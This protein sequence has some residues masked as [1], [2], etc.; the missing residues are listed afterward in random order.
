MSKENKVLRKGGNANNPKD[1][2]MCSGDPTCPRHVHLQ[3]AVKNTPDALNAVIS[4]EVEKDITNFIDMHQPSLKE[5][6]SNENGKIIAT[7]FPTATV[8]LASG[9]G[10]VYIADAIA[11]GP[12][13]FE[14]AFGLAFM[15][16][17]M[18]GLFGGMAGYFTNKKATKNNKA[19]HLADLYEQETKTKLSKNERHMFKDKVS[20]ELTDE[21]HHQNQLND[22]ALQEELNR[23]FLEEYNSATKNT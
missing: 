10:A 5:K 12:V 23:K 8:A 13:A 6:N 18:G 17:I 2:E 11:G 4:A 3:K 14:L 19:N 15:F 9:G 21:D 1:W 7:L 16:G 20:L 22:K